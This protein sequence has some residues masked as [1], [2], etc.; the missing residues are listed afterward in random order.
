MSIYDKKYNIFL[1]IFL[2]HFKW[3]GTNKPVPVR[4]H[5]KTHGGGARAMESGSEHR[6]TEGSRKCFAEITRDIPGLL[7]KEYSPLTQ[8]IVQLDTV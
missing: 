7:W 1:C 6:P 3:E 5:S 4:I 8:A 2:L